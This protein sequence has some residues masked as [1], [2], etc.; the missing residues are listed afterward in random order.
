[1]CLKQDLPCKHFSNNTTQTPNVNFSIIR[2]SQN[3]FRSSI[4]SG[5]NV[6][7]RFVMEKDTRT[8][9]DNFHCLICVRLYHDVL[10]LQISVGDVQFMQFLQSSQNLSCDYLNI[11]KVCEHLSVHLIRVKK[12][13]FKQ[14]G[15]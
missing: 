15:H 2:D 11:P 6:V 9:I 5:L 8:Q 4:T 12:C 10:R 13:I 7:S 14:V 1:M 3:N